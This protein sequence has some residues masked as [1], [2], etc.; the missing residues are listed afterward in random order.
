[1]PDEQ[2]IL[3]LAKVLIAAA[4]S[5][6]ELA[7]EEINSM[8]DLLYQIPQ[9]SARQWASLSMYIES[10]VDDAE[11]ARL[12][13]ELRSAIRTEQDKELTLTA[14]DAMV[15]ADGRTTDQ[16]ESAVTGIK[17]AVETVDVG[18]LTNLVKGLAGRRSQTVAS[19]PNR[20]EYLEDFIQNKVYYGVRRRLDLGEAEIDLS[21]KQLRT[22]SLAG[23]IMAQIAHIN[24]QITDDEVGRMVDALETYWHLSTEQAA[25]VASVA[26]SETASLLDRYRLTREFADACTYEERVE[27]LDVLFAVAAADGMASYEEIEEIRQITQILKLTHEEFIEAK[28]K[29]PD[30]QRAQ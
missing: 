4:W 14:L 6:G 20:E 1:M 19:A 24:P 28:L 23:G 12:V 15:A 17:A 22:L 26:I 3:T 16:E 25:F 27:F 18:F 9:L 11:R 21:E 2:L 8:K 5:D 13:E 30:D 10:P 7:L 29:L